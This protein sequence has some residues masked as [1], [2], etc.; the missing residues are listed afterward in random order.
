MVAVDALRRLL[1]M[2]IY[3]FQ[4]VASEARAN[5]AKRAVDIKIISC[6]QSGPI[7]TVSPCF[8]VNILETLGSKCMEFGKIL[9]IGLYNLL[10][11][12]T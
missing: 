6:L 12:A 2:W 9:R 3:C 8:I 1:I 4:G 10:S 7:K 5:T 11:V